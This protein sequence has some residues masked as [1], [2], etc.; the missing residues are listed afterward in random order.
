MKN[1]LSEKEKLFCA[2][3]ANF[4]NVKEAAIYAKLGKNGETAALEI[5]RKKTATAYIKKQ[6]LAKAQIKAAVSLRRLAFGRCND[7]VKLMFMQ[8]EEVLQNIDELDLFNVY[9]IKKSAT[10]NL[11]IKFFDKIKAL[12]VLYSSGEEFDDDKS[13]GFFDALK[14][15]VKQEE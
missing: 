9:E 1:N 11:E 14:N 10:G 12:S 13:S 8:P 4:G 2:Y 15:A 6:S 7:A 5:L 3:Y